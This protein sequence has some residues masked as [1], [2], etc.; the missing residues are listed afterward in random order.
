M[1][2]HEEGLVV[3]LLAKGV[4]ERWDQ[5]V[6]RHRVSTEP[7]LPP[8]AIYHHVEDPNLLSMT[9]KV[10]N[11]LKPS[12]LRPTK[13]ILTSLSRHNTTQVEYG[14]GPPAISSRICRLCV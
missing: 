14:S 12:P 10:G 9:V 1:V 5:E 2:Q 13:R 3:S 6:S 4:A 11:R 7:P 8:L